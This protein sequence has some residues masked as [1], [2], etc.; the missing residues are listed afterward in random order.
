[1]ASYLLIAGGLVLLILGGELLVRGAADGAARLGMSP[2]LIGLTLVGFGTSTPELVTS[3]Q[4]SLL[5]SPG[6]AIGNIVGSNIANVLLILGLAALLSPI[7]VGDR[8]L[9]RDGSIVVLSAASF[10]A[11]GFLLP[12]DRFVGAALVALLAGYLFYAYRQETAGTSGR[13]TV[14]YDKVEAHDAAFPRH[15]DDEKG[16]GTGATTV[17]LPFIVALAGLAVVVLGGKLLVE[18]A[19][20]AAR[21][22][23]VSEGVIGLTVVAVGTSLPEL[24]TS[25][26]AVLRRHPDVALG[27]VLGSNIYNILGIGGVTALISPTVIPAEIARFDNIVMLAVS[28]AL[29]FLAWTGRRIARPEGALLLF[30]YALY[31][32]VIWPVS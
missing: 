6:I 27:N 7:A 14:A 29:L 18:G 13:H 31:V 16:I 8:A 30:C 26:V 20:A 1:M 5:G 2:L 28:A 9:R 24:V 12:L 25:V 32:F 15:D 22:S 10:V 17:W 4:A 21:Q 19:I 3:V 11:I 23:G